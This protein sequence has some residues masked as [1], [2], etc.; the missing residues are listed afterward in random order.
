LYLAGKLLS[1]TFAKKRL[2]GVLEKIIFISE[3]LFGIP[4][5]LSE[6]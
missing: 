6:T 2:S 1:F 4:E 5:N 3:R